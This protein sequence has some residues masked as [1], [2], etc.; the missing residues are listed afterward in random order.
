MDSTWFMA[1][2]ST[3]NSCWREILLHASHFKRTIRGLSCTLRHIEIDTSRLNR[4]YCN[5]DQLHKAASLSGS[6]HQTCWPAIHDQRSEK[7]FCFPGYNRKGALIFLYITVERLDVR[8]GRFCR[9]ARTQNGLHG[10]CAKTLA[11][12]VFGAGRF[13]R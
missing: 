12:F 2:S 1:D 4:C 9:T 10:L 7:R 11:S 8:N 5:P 13:D 6:R 3:S